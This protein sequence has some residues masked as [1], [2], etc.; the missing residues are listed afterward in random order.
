MSHVR[1][2]CKRPLLLI[3]LTMAAMFALAG[4]ARAE[5][6]GEIT[7]FGG[8]G[9]AHGKLTPSILSSSGEFFEWQPWHV[10]GVNP[11]DND[12]F[13]LEEYEEAEEKHKEE[14]HFYRL[15]ELNTK[16]EL[17]GYHQFEFKVP[18]GENYSQSANKDTIEG[19][20][21]DPK[22]P[23]GG[24]L[25]FLVD[26]ERPSHEE[27]EEGNE[28]FPGEEEG[29]AAALYAFKLQPNGSKELEP[30]AQAASTGVLDNQEKLETMADIKKPLTETPGQPLL[31]PRGITVDPHTHEVVILAHVDDA[32][33]EEEEPGEIECEPDELGRPYVHYVTQRVMENGDLGER[34][35]DTANVLKEQKGLTFS[36]PGSPVVAGPEAAERTL[37]EHLVEPTE[38]VFEKT[39]GEFPALT[40]GATKEFALPDTAGEEEGFDE[41]IA[42]PE[43]D[44]GGDL[45]A[46][47]GGSELYGLTR[48]DNEESAHHE[49]L[50]AISERSAETLAPIGWS[51]GQAAGGKDECV[52][53]PE[54]FEGEHIQIAAGESGDIFALV[55]EYLHKA[56]AGT[57]FPTH[58]AI[59]E[60][61]PGGKGCPAAS[62][63]KNVVLLDG[64]EDAS[65]VG[66]G[67]PVTLSTFVKQGDALSV[68]WKIESE[69]TKA[70]VTETQTE[71]QYQH[72]QLPYT[73]TVAG[74]YKITEEIKTDNLDTPT[75][76]TITRTVVVEEKNE[77]PTVSSQPSSVTV[78]EG[79][80]ATFTAT[81]TGKPVP[82]PQW[83]VSTDGGKT[84]AKD[85][86]DRGALK[87]TLEVEATAAKSG[88]E[89]YAIFTNSNK[90]S[91]Q[92]ATATLTV[93][94]KKAGGE[95][96]PPT[97]KS[98][99]S[100]P[101]TTTATT[102]PPS[103]GVLP[104][105]VVAP[106]ATIA[107]ASS[108][109]VAT[110][111]ALT[112]KITCPTGATTCTGTLSLR[113][114]TAVSA[115]GK[116]KKSIL[117]LATGSFSVVGGQTKSI[118]LHLSATGRK[119]LAKL[120]V[121]HAR[122]T[123]A[124]HDP[125]GEHATTTK[126]ITLR[127]APAKHKH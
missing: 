77:A 71:D 122:A 31:E 95:P 32:K 57:E 13:V 126:S 9:A 88:Y 112:V 18:S 107:G 120:H 84:F 4:V 6:F 48:I 70:T 14:I 83:W 42:E 56:A 125:A 105:K 15:Q 69:T 103:N 113:T 89:Y 21:V 16:G 20:A 117:T 98:P 22:A 65:P 111:G 106:A 2:I 5:S 46:S 60:F 74:K 55:P 11:E 79:A 94:P 72:P 53:E 104:E 90:E 8:P 127:P 87:D 23:G 85:S 34:S 67:V 43:G 66:T 63:E 102:P 29:A 49:S 26:Q 39:I 10:I 37:A 40:S 64:K 58:D 19:I 86:E 3:G 27:V 1:V 44:I 81:A 109:N 24:R 93:T 62:A 78:E 123:I 41:V 116:G 92:T 30:V 28:L 114:A 35:I 115:S 101:T 97:P 110:S 25:Y 52:L 73:F 54:D 118:T 75:L 124:A 80:L 17:L 61:G 51:G 50:Y 96:P 59:I 7:R 99:E 119:L 68:V 45:V 33:C 76:P 108:V 91:A 100:P 82:S 36:S 121:L 12:V 47:P 38:G